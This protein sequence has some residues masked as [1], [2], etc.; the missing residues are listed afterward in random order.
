MSELKSAWEIA[1]ERANR[2]GK[3]SAEEIEQQE[4]EKCLQSGRALAQKLLDSPQQLD[5][6]A[7]L[8]QYD[9][10][11]RSLVRRSAIEY[12]VTAIAL[13]KSQSVN[14]TKIAIRAITSLKPELQAEARE[15][16]QLV[17][18]FEQSEQKI[19]EE[20]ENKHREVLHQLRI[21]GTAIAGT[22]VEADPE[23]QPA[24]QKLLASFTPRLNA[25][26]QA[27]L[28]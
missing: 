10:K 4:R 12:L 25:L 19:R 24:H 20:L 27:L 16:D 28:S 1:Q 17:Q 26:K 11:A 15:I 18:E 9:E 8:N 13:A 14:K 5:I 22:N 2:L 3:L 6:D 21:S 23:W 7:E